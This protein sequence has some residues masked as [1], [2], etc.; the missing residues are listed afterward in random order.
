MTNMVYRTQQT[1]NRVSV[2]C[3]RK[4]DSEQDGASVGIHINDDSNHD[5]DNSINNSSHF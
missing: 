3:N 4:R 5:D 1:V 2:P